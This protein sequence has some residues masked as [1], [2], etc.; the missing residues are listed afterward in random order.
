MT[1]KHLLPHTATC[2]PA[3]QHREENNCE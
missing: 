2:M 1:P 3:K